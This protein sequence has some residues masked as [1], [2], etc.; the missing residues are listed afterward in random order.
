MQKHVYLHIFIHI[1]LL[2]VT[3]SPRFT[4]RMTQF[5]RDSTEK[6]SNRW[7]LSTFCL[8]CMLMAQN[9]GVLQWISFGRI[10]DLNSV[11]YASHVMMCCCIIN[12][13]MFAMKVFK[14]IV[15]HFPAPRKT[16][17]HRWLPFRFSRLQSDFWNGNIRMISAALSLE[18]VNNCARLFNCVS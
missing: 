7:P 16:G 3:A 2:K 17:P 1:L 12:C 5:V 8:I 10:V 15:C 9:H 6:H 14:S 4:N 18:Y 13:E 11:I